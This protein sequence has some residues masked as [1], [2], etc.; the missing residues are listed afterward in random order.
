MAL[1]FC[2]C[3]RTSRKFERTCWQLSLTPPLTPAYP[4]HQ[5]DDA[6]TQT[7]DL[8]ALRFSNAEERTNPRCIKKLRTRIDKTAAGGGNRRPGET[9]SRRCIDPSPRTTCHRQLLNLSCPYLAPKL[10]N[11]WLLGQMFLTFHHIVVRRHSSVL[12]SIRVC[13]HPM[14]SVRSIY[15]THIESANPTAH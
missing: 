1:C 4:L 10:V 12:G 14:P 15:G 13:Q 9:A 5:A 6:R 11:S 2:A 3:N 8:S 7:L